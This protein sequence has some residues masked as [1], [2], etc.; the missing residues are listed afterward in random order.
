MLKNGV[1]L[2]IYLIAKRKRMNSC[3]DSKVVASK[4]LHKI[5]FNIVYVSVNLIGN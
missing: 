3:I 4:K 1:K 5:K 2:C